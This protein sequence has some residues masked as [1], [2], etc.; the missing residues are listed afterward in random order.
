VGSGN[1]LKKSFWVGLKNRACH[2]V[3]NVID[4]HALQAS[5]YTAAG[6]P[7]ETIKPIRVFHFFNTAQ[8]R[9]LTIN[10]F[11]LIM[12]FLEIDAGW[13]SLVAR[14]AHNPKVIGSNPVPATTNIK[15]LQLITVAPFYL[16]VSFFEN[17]AITLACEP[18]LTT[19]FLIM[20]SPS[21]EGKLTTG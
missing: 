2:P 1:P 11:S 4:S 17:N 14:R 6:P 9:L 5:G 10:G 13:S 8:I 19:S 7:R 16:G 12:R 21:F 15:G 20:V 3:V 18:T